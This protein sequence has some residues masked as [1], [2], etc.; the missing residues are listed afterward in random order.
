MLFERLED[1]YYYIT[2]DIL[3]FAGP[4]GDSIIMFPAMREN[5]ERIFSLPSHGARR[6][7]SVAI[8]EA[9]D[10]WGLRSFTLGPKTLFKS[11]ISFFYFNVFCVSS[12]HCQQLAAVICKSVGLT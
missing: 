4:L 2:I 7:D 5:K 9:W 3:I 10:W 12:T 6:G 8:G 1:H 11:H